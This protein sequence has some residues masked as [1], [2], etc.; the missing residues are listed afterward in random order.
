MIRFLVE[1][2]VNPDLPNRDNMTPLHLACVEQFEEIIL[3]LIKLGVNIN[4]QDNSGNSAL[5]YLLSGKIKEYVN[6]E[7]KPLMKK[8]KKNVKKE[9]AF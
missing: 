8:P 9:E 2:R 7:K 3:Y 1:N 6:T 4:Y 5:H